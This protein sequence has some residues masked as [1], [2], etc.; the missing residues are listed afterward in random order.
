MAQKA[1]PM[2]TMQAT[3]SA[4]VF[5]FLTLLFALVVIAAAVVD[6]FKVYVLPP[7]AIDV[8]LLL[9]GLKLLYW[10]VERGFEKKRKEMF[11][12]YI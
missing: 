3:K 10:G 5:P 2:P 4:S 6:Y 7:L 11:K 9:A 1:Q 12:R 8:I